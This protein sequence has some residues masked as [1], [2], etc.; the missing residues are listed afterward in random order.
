MDAT[1]GETVPYLDSSGVT[2]FAK[3]VKDNFVYESELATVAKT[4]NYTD[5]SGRPVAATADQEGLMSAAD[6]EKL[7]GIEAGAQVNE[8]VDVY[9][10][11]FPFVNSVT[12]NAGSAPTLGADIAADEITGWDAGT[13][14]TMGESIEADNI[15]GWN[16]GTAATMDVSDGVLN[17]NSGVAPTLTHEDKTIPVIS[18]VGTVPTLTK[19]T[20]SIPNVTDAGAAPSL[21]YSTQPAVVQVSTAPINPS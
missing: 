14:P 8:E 12:W 11:T 13:A 2:R 4:G 3:W 20:K 7:D 10:A 16:A 1:K 18:S 6:K 19:S 15:T 5:L 17:L 21:T 9:T